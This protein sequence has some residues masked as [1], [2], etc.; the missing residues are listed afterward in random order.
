MARRVIRKEEMRTIFSE[1]LLD[2]SGAVA[3]EYRKR[4]SKLDKKKV[5]HSD[6]D[7]FIQ[8]G[9]VAGRVLNQDT[10]LARDK[11]HQDQKKQE[12]AW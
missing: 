3:K 7:E 11:K 12:P 8:K 4:N 10:W 2:E 6:V 9:W 5:R 1:G